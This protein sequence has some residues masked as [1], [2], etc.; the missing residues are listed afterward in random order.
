MKVFSFFLDLYQSL[1][2]FFF[3]LMNNL[4]G[5]PFGQVT[6]SQED[7]AKN[8]LFP[9]INES[10]NYAEEMYK[11]SHGTYG[12]GEQKTR[13]YNW[14]VDPNKTTF[15]MK[16]KDVAFNGVSKNIADILT[17]SKEESGPLVVESN[18]S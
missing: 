12:V 18:V 9:R 11:K 15:G 8:L 7:T 3:K 17:T 13:N 14:K 6:K 4:L 1:S 16:G 2:I 5:T 10:P